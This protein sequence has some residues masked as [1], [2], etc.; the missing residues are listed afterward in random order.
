MVLPPLPFHLAGRLRAAAAKLAVT[1]VVATPAA[2]RLKI[3]AAENVYGVVAASIAGPAADVSSVLSNPAQDPHDFEASAEVAREVASA[4]IVVVNGVDFDPWMDRLLGAS[5]R[6]GREVIR[7]ADL[8]GAHAGDNPHLWYA[9]GTMVSFAEALT[10][11]LTA[12]DAADAP[13]FEQREKVFAAR[14]NEV[15]ATIADMRKHLAGMKVTATE[16]VFGPMAA[17]LGMSMQDQRFQLAVMN[18]TEPRAGDVAAIE[19]DLRG[20][21]VKILFHNAQVSDTASDRLIGIAQAAGLQVV[22]IA[23]LI[24][25][26][27]DYVAWIMSELAAVRRAAGQSQ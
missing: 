23:E 4:D 12:W 8:V 18:G 16:P 17:A 22:G 14:M 19:D 21:R 7:V 1:F 25:P 6:P 13:A 27:M 20:R 5:E 24:P 10:A 15:R 3:L 26:G 11:K 9:P 2:A